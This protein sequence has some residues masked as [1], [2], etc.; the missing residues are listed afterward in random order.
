MDLIVSFFLDIVFYGT[1]DMADIKRIPVWKRVALILIMLMGA[2]VL[3]I[4]LYVG[5][6]N[7]QKALAIGSVLILLLIC[8]TVHIY[9]R[10]FYKKK[11]DRGE[12]S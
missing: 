1:L 8:L 4:M 5:V 10:W 12:V 6:V 3:G 9:A 7:N 2:G 11:E